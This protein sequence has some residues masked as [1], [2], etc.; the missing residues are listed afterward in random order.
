MEIWR[1][2]FRIFCE[3]EGRTLGEAEWRRLADRCRDLYGQYRGPF[4]LR[5]GIMLM[6]LFGDLHR[7]GREPEQTRMAE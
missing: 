1:E 5:M 3:N 2:G 4:A 6:D 7:T